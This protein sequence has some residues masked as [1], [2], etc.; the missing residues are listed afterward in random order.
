MSKCRNASAFENSRIEFKTQTLTLASHVKELA[1][2]RSE[3]SPG[4]KVELERRMSVYLP[5]AGLSFLI[6]M[7]AGPIARELNGG[8]G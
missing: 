1:G 7:N 4:Q 2:G 6:A 3:L 8:R 5:D